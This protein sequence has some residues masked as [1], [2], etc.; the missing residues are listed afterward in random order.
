MLWGTKI[1]LFLFLLWVP[2]KAGPVADLGAGFVEA[3]LKDDDE[4]LEKLVALSDKRKAAM[5]AS[6]REAAGAIE[7]GA[8]SLKAIDRELVI[9][10]LGVTLIKFSTKGGESDYDPLVCMKTKEGWRAVPWENEEDARKFAASRTSD[11]QIHLK[12][13]DEWADLVVEEIAK[14]GAKKE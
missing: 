8:I 4:G 10:D 6:F 13:F 7:A 3:V 11:E 14:E 1:V 5:L 9:G 12:L 2:A